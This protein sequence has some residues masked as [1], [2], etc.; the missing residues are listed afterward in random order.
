MKILRCFPVFLILFLSVLNAFAQNKEV[1]VLARTGSGILRGTTEENICVWRGIKYA[2]AERFG[3]PH[4]PP[5]WKGVQDALKFGAVA[6]QTKSMISSKE[7]QSED[8]LFLNIWSP[9]ADSLKRPVMV[10]IHGGSLVAGSGSQPIYNGLKLARN[11]DVVV[12]TINYRL[13]P[14]G[15]LYFNTPVEGNDTLGN[16][17]GIHDQIAALQWVKENIA[18]FGGNPDRVTIFGE[19]AGATSVQ[20]LLA[21]P[22]AKGLFIAAIAQSGT[23]AMVW[24]PSL[25][26]SIT[27][28]YFSFLRLNPTNKHLLKTLPLDSLKAAQEKLLKYMLTTDNKV[29]APT[30]DGKVLTADIF[31][32]IDQQVNAR[33]PLLLGTN[34]DESTI[35]VKT[36]KTAPKNAKQLNE[37]IDR[38]CKNDKQQVLAG[39]EKY[40]RKA[41]VM[42]ILTDALF[43]VPNI[44]LSEQ[45]LVYA[46]V[47][48]YRFEWCSFFLKVTGLRSFHGIEMPF[49]F[50]STDRKTGRLLKVVAT[51]KVIKQLS[52]AMQK[53]WTNFARYGNPNGITSETWKPY[54][55]TERATMIFDKKCSIAQDPDKIQR[56]AWTGVKYY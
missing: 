28:K 22:A 36:M 33:V 15:F 5:P 4:A 35:F 50:G 30:I 47:Y 49:I 21:S 11:G 3:Y 34:N 8:C 14:L 54:T 48:L 44:R 20:T 38:I 52:G 27:K 56:Q 45:R 10:W 41:A 40:P 55:T 23:P 7:P 32:S 24:T 39:Y 37:Y 26:D 2:E 46:P 13:G 17:L 16:N 31:S 51:K 42:E 12:V 9:C 1:E 25:A 18:A 19:S 29:F 6:V 53:A 43:R